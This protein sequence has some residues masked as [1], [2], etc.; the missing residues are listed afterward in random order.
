MFPR[1][2]GSWFTAIVEERFQSYIGDAMGSIYLDSLLLTDAIPRAPETHGQ[3]PD[4][5][6]ATVESSPGDPNAEGA[7][8][9]AP[10]AMDVD[11]SAND[12]EPRSIRKPGVGSDAAG[13][14]E[15]PPIAEGKLVSGSAE[16]VESDDE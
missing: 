4:P 5:K 10:A 15:T 11:A 13:Q 2:A 9:G 1:D 8:P 3:G 16:P 14:T 12:P 7:G 6:K